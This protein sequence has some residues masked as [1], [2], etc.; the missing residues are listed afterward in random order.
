MCPPDHPVIAVSSRSAKTLVGDET[1][2]KVDLQE[3]PAKNSTSNS[4][5]ECFPS[6]VYPVNPDR[7]LVLMGSITTLCILSSVVRMERPA[8]V[9]VL[10]MLQE[11]HTVSGTWKPSKEDVQ[12]L[13]SGTW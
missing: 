5:A 9:S 10:V 1:S 4:T 12:P 3:P 8:G 6:L 7:N 11:T 2:K 13:G